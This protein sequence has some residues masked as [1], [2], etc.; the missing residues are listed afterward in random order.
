ML[1]A[2]IGNKRQGIGRYAVFYLLVFALAAAAV[3]EI[4]W[5]LALLPNG[6]G[7]ASMQEEKAAA[8]IEDVIEDFYDDLIAGNYEDLPDYCTGDAEEAFEDAIQTGVRNPFGVYRE[9]ELAEIDRIKIDG[10]EASARAELTLGGETQKEDFELEYDDGD[11]LI[12]DWDGLELLRNPEAAHASP[13]GEEAAVRTAADAFLNA[14]SN[15]DFDSMLAMMTEEFATETRPLVRQLRNSDPDVIDKRRPVSWSVEEVL[16]RGDRYRLN[17]S[18]RL[19]GNPDR[20]ERLGMES[21]KADAGWKVSNIR[22]YWYIEGD[23]E[24]EGPAVEEPS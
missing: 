6:C 20:P 22:S 5:P 19:K 1:L 14:F 23:W 17:V 9:A 12:A 3:G 7:P 11:W 4:L 24:D 16:T 10:E 2:V 18:V 8:E 15:L 21:S 13:P